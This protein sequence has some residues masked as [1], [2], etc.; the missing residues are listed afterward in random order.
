MPA[1]QQFSFVAGT[2]GVWRVMS[3]RD[4]CGGGLGGAQRLDVTGVAL[5]APSVLPDGASWQLR[6]VTSND[7]YVTRSEKA[8]LVG[9]QPPLGR[10]GATCAALIPIQKSKEWWELTQDERRAIFEARSQHI[11][12]GV[13]YLPAIARRLHHCRDLGEPFD[14]LTWFEYAPEDGPAFED[15]LGA[16]RA[17]EEWRY[18]VREVEVRVER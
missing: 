7:R 9:R 15:L 4:V 8:E 1:P 10:P 17:T 11:E 3:V 5:S 13:R 2:V 12:I 16:L 18:V 6:G 14:F